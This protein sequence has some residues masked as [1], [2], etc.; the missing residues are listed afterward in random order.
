MDFIELVANHMR[1]DDSAPSSP[2]ETYAVDSNL[3]PW[4]E[5]A[6]RLEAIAMGSLVGAAL[7]VAMKGG[8]S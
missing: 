8:G 1:E 2:G 4:L 6:G 3:I 5:R 7:F